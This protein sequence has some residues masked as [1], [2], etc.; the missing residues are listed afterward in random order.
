MSPGIVHALGRLPDIALQAGLVCDIAACRR[1]RSLY[2]GAAL[3]GMSFCSVSSY[4]TQLPADFACD[5]QTDPEPLWCSCHSSMPSSVEPSATATRSLPTQRSDDLQT[6]R[7]PFSVA[8]QGQLKQRAPPAS[9][10]S[11]APGRAFEAR[12]PAQ[13]KLP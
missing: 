6:R 7:A 4:Q 8:G 9:P 1:A 13:P 5:K 12:N 2:A 10:T 3:P 11:C